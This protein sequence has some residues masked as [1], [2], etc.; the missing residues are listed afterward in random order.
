MNAP[1]AIVCDDC[2]T[3][4]LQL[5]RML[6]AL[7]CRVQILAF[8]QLLLPL[9]EA[10]AVVCVELFGAAH[11]GF[12][13]LRHWRRHYD[14]KLL[15]ISASGRCT[16]DAWGVLAGATAVLQRPFNAAALAQYLPVVRAA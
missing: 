8:D 16:D 9:A 10:P 13:Q 2:A 7:G 6:V 12:K 4:A 5:S 15:L 1:L 3:Q 11:N 14:C